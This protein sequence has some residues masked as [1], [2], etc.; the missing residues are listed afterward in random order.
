VPQAVAILLVAQTALAG[1]ALFVLVDGPEW[2]RSHIRL[3]ALWTALIG[4]IV[5]LALTIP[6]ALTEWLSRP[7]C[8]YRK[9]KT[10]TT[11]L[12]SP[13]CK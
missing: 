7:G 1:I 4:G 9:P 6:G 13:R 5:D 12:P 8:P 11:R 10:L 3:I 2:V